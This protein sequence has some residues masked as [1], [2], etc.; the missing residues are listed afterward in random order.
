LRLDTAGSGGLP[1]CAPAL[2]RVLCC[3]TDIG[4]GAIVTAVAHADS[5][6]AASGCAGH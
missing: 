4:T 3:C 2:D 6:E 5:T 1:P